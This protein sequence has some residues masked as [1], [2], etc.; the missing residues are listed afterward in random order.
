MEIFSTQNGL[1]SFTDEMGRI[2]NT[3]INYSGRYQVVGTAISHKTKYEGVVLNDS[4][5]FRAY[6][7]SEEFCGTGIIVDNFDTEKHC[8]V[9]E[10]F[11]INGSRCWLLTKEPI[12]ENLLHWIL[13]GEDG[14]WKFCAFTGNYKKC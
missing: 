6:K 7:D 3:I 9:T 1:I 4:G 13:I 14:N 8:I 10:H 12:H 2:H 5:E 11:D